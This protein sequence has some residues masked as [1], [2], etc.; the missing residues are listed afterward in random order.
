MVI[1]RNQ[2]LE[3]RL[4]E[5]DDLIQQMTKLI[6]ITR[7]KQLQRKLLKFNESAANGGPSVNYYQEDPMA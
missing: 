1:Q 7:N 4:L 5:A 3:N 6:D 2:F